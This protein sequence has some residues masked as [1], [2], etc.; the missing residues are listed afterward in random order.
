VTL[1]YER[2]G[3]L[4]AQAIVETRIGGARVHGQLTVLSCIAARTI[5]RVT[6]SRAHARASVGTRRAGAHVHGVLTQ[7]VGKPN[8]TIAPERARS[9][10]NAR[11]SVGTHRL[12]ASIDGHCA[13]ETRVSNGTNTI[14]SSI[15]RYARATVGTRCIG[16]CV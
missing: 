1:K 16:T 6:G 11:R 10:E 7:R 9:R 14:E 3:C 15:G 13:V 12:V 2:I 5:A 8:R 4:S